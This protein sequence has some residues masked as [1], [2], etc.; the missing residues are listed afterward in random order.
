[1]ESVVLDLLRKKNLTLAIAESVTGGLVSGRL[2][3]VAGASD[4]FR[5][6]VVSYASEVKYEVLGITNEV[7]VTEAAA[8]EMA[9]GVRKALGSDIGLALT[10]VAGPSEQQGV[11]VGTLC[12]GVAMP[13]GSTKSMTMHLPIGRE[14]MRQLSVISALNFLR[15]E[16]R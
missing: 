3:A 11:K 2:T 14:Q 7:V 1:M 15:N 16:L 13:D 12:V 6:A 9:T 10:G 4:V 8:K 5:G